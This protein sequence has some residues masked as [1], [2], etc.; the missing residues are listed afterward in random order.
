MDPR[1]KEE[2]EEEHENSKRER[3]ARRTIHYIENHRAVSLV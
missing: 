2:Y 1:D 3:K